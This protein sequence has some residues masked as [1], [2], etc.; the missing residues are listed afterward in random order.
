MRSKL[1]FLFFDGFQLQFV[2]TGMRS[3]DCDER[4][5][6][7]WEHAKKHKPDRILEDLQVYRIATGQTNSEDYAAILDKLGWDAG[8]LSDLVI[9]LIATDA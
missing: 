3:V 1:S 6:K 9:V 2:P 5:P 7:P 8:K 4:E